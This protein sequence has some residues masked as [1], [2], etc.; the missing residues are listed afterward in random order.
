M[1][2]NLTALSRDEDR[3]SNANTFDPDRFLEDSRD[4]LSSAPSS[5]HYS[6]DHF[7]YGFGRRFCQ[8]LFVA[9]ASLYIIISRVVWGFDISCQPGHKL[10]M[11][12]KSC[13]PSFSRVLLF[14]EADFAGNIQA[15]LATKPKPFRVS[16]KSR[17]RQH[18]AIMKRSLGEETINIRDIADLK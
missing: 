12:A 9:E 15:G 6:R 8:G 4:A 17:S 3:Y 1:F 5:D 13:R 11:S 18:E 2:P 14:H 16:I 7:Q 10:D